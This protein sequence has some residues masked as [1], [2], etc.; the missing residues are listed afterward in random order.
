MGILPID[1]YI[2]TTWNMLI[3]CIIFASKCEYH[4][5]L[6]GYLPFPSFKRYNENKQADPWQYDMLMSTLLQT[7]PKSCYLFY[8]AYTF[9]NANMVL[10]FLFHSQ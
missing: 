1:V 9:N 10:I 6:F 8:T 4:L 7:L 2:F 5:A 3:C